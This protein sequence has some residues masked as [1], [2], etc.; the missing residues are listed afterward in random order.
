MLSYLKQ[1]ELLNLKERIVNNPALRQRLTQMIGLSKG[2][3]E[4]S[5][6]LGSDYNVVRHLK[7]MAVS[8]LHFSTRDFTALRAEVFNEEKED[9]LRHP[10]RKAVVILNSPNAVVE[11]TTVSR[12]PLTI[13][14]ARKAT[15]V[16]VVVNNKK[17]IETIQISHD[18]NLP[19]YIFGNVEELICTGQRLT[20]CYLVNCPNLSRLD[21]SNNQLAKMRLC[22]SMPKLRDIDI[23]TNILPIETIG[24]M[25]LSLCQLSPENLFDT[26]PQI[27][28]DSNITGELSWQAKQKGWIIK[29]V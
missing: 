25:L 3:R 27:L 22:Q 23:R 7:D 13:T 2:W 24:K 12:K 8:E 4:L 19:I 18:T 17:P 28:T 1:I 11:L 5:E 15:P 21:V 26:A 9:M 14:T 10:K 6:E 20:E 16:S 29:N